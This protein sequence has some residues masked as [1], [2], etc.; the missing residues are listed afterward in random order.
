MI[1]MIICSILIT[2]ALNISEEK[3]DHL[4]VNDDNTKTKTFSYTLLKESC[5]CLTKRR[6]AV[7]RVKLDWRSPSG[8][9]SCPFHHGPCFRRLTESGTSPLHHSQNHLSNPPCPAATTSLHKGSLCIIFGA[10]RE[11]L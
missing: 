6:L 3:L 4:A 9:Q 7:L 8:L 10:S 11:R 1:G 2:I 5:F